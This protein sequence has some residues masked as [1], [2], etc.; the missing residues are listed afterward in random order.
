MSSDGVLQASMRNFVSEIER[1]AQHLGFVAR[2][3]VFFREL[4]VGLA[5]D[6]AARWMACILSLRARQ[7][8]Q[9]EDARERQEE[10]GG[11]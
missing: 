11:G 6:R 3:D 8:R 2:R 9:D 4:S 1:R 10:E 5:R 7:W